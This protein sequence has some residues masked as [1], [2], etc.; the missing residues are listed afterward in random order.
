MTKKLSSVGTPSK[1]SRREDIRDKSLET[2]R[3]LCPRGSTIYYV[4][5][6]VSKSGMSRTIDF[7]TIAESYGKQELVYLSGY[8]SDVLGYNR[9]RQGSLKVSGC[10]MDMGF[11]VV[12]GVSCK[13]YCESGYDHDAAYSIRASQ[14]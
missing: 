4:I 5:R 9:N 11:H 14:I 6:S 13:L 2:L 10:G 8:I 7:Y 3:K 1:L 12:Y